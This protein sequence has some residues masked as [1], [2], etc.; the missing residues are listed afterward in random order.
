MLTF[1]NIILTK[2][3]KASNKA[4]ATF[5]GFDEGRWILKYIASVSETVIKIRT[6]RLKTR[7]P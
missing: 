7:Q 3:S 2:P 1:F 4:M 6:K 5:A